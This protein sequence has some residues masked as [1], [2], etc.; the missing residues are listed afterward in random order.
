MRSQN[1]V[2][3]LLNQDLVASVR[4]EYQSI[5]SSWCVLKCRPCARAASSSRPTRARGGVVK[6]TLG[7]PV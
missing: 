1:A 6:T 2:G 7:I 3:P 4:E 5:V